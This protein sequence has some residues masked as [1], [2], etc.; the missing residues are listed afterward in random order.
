MKILIPFLVSLVS[1]GCSQSQN[2][3]SQPVVTVGPRMDVQYSQLGFGR[4]NQEDS[5]TVINRELKIIQEHADALAK[6]GRIPTNYGSPERFLAQ[7]GWH[8]TS[9]GAFGAYS[10]YQPAFEQA[11]R[12]WIFDGYMLPGSD[13][14]WVMNSNIRFDK[15]AIGR[16][17]AFLYESGCYRDDGNTPCEPDAGGKGQELRNATVLDVFGHTFEWRSLTDGSHG[18]EFWEGPLKLDKKAPAFMRQYGIT[19]MPVDWIDMCACAIP[20]SSASPANH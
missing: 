11:K 19:L 5:A 8:Y 17:V 14:L 16:T 7:Y 4:Q 18:A 9:K 20:T 12:M 10:F 15:S 2:K 3:A 1:S 6:L 13:L